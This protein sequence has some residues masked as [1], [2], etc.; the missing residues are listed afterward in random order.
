MKWEWEV[1]RSESS[2]EKRGRENPWSVR[3]LALRNY[4]HC[5]PI[6]LP[7]SDSVLS[8]SHL[9]EGFRGLVFS[10]CSLA[11]LGCQA[12]FFNMMMCLT[13][14]FPE[15][16]F[17]SPGSAK[18]IL[19]DLCFNSRRPSVLFWFP[20][21][22]EGEHPAGLHQGLSLSVMSLAFAALMPKCAAGLRAIGDTS[23]WEGGSRLQRFPRTDVG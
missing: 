4:K 8:W 17:C 6:H 9:A 2:C 1:W 23:V 21:F 7:S 10:K 18:C 22:H 20:F 3:C 12:L 5:L 16:K 19:A 13:G 14:R 15:E 11:A